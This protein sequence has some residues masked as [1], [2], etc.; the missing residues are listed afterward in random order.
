MNDIFNILD[1]PEVIFASESFQ[2]IQ[3]HYKDDAENNSEEEHI[4]WRR[5][6]FTRLLM[7]N[8]LVWKDKLEED[9]TVWEAMDRYIVEGTMDE[10]SSKIPLYYKNFMPIESHS[11]FEEIVD[12]IRNELILYHTNLIYSKKII[13][14][15]DNEFAKDGAFP[16]Q[17]LFLRQYLNVATS[18]MILVS[19]KL[20]SPTNTQK[21]ISTGF[22]YLKNYVA[23]NCGE[24][25]GVK[26]V[27][28]SEIR[29]LL[30][31]GSKKCETLVKVRNALIAHYDIKKISEIRD[32]RINYDELKELY[33]LSVLILQ[34]LS[35]YRFERMSCIYPNLI[36]CQGFE[37]AICQNPWMGCTRLDIDDYFSVLRQSFVSNLI[38]TNGTHE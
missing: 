27:L 30:K 28:G 9:D 37:K 18:E 25:S 1:N 2:K 21:N 3:Q 34:K 24:N 38:N 22:P 17:I 36:R 13:D 8:S 23:K 16:T 15:L 11:E 20:F 12:L 26:G 6:G 33:Q 7:K 32:I 19:T 29:T 14:F 10:Y 31:D 5:K 4:K 35:F